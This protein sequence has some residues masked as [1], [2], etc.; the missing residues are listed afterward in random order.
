MSHI[1]TTIF[2]RFITILLVIFASFHVVRGQSTDTPI[3]DQSMEGMTHADQAIIQQMLKLRSEK[4][5]LSHG[6]VKKRLNL[7]Q[8]MEV[9]LKQPSTRIL[10]VEEVAQWAR[11]ANFRVGYCYLCPHC[12]NWHLNLAAAYAVSEKVLVTCDHVV[13]IAEDIREGYLIAVSHDGVV[14]PISAI[15]ARS[16]DMD[17]VVL[18]CEAASFVPMA[19]QTDVQQGAASYCYS[20]PLGQFGYFSDG[21][22]NRFYW[23]QG[24]RGGAMDQLDSLRFLRINVSTDW[25]PGS[26][27]S[28]VFDRCGN[29]IAHVSQIA[30]LGEQ[31]DSQPLVTIHTGVPARAV[32]KLLDICHQ[33]EALKALYEVEKKNKGS[34]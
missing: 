15:I 2:F 3:M 16:K 12:D 1:A 28:A 22:V 23:D 21:I 20:S 5:L 19:L 33:P 4:K 8:P 26:S 9:A 27:G 29:V 34:Q 7:P 17:A 11:Q 10:S 25:A 13:D 6:E 30:P 24:Y 14:I 32:K 18:H 31:Q